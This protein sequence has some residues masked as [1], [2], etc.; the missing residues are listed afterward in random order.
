MSS[1][2]VGLHLGDRVGTRNRRNQHDVE[3]GP[4]ALRA[5]FAVGELVEGFE[6]RN[7]VELA[8]ALDDAA[9]HRVE[10]ARIAF[11]Q[12]LD[13]RV[14]LGDPGSFVEP[15]GDL[16]ERF[17]IEF[18]EAGA[19]PFNS[20][21]VAGECRLGFEVAEEVALAGARDAD[22]EASGQ[23]GED[24]GG[25]AARIGVGLVIA[26]R[27]LKDGESVVDVEREDGDR[28]EGAARRHDAGSGERAERGLQSDDAV[29]RRRHA[30]RPRRVGSER[31][32][33]DPGGDRN[34]RARARAAGDEVRAERVA[35]DAIGRTDADE[36][37]GELV[38]IGLADD[39]R[40]GLLQPLD[41]ERR[42]LRPV[43]EGGA[44]GRG[45]QA[46]DVDVVLDRERDA[47]Q[48]FAR[49]PLG[50]Q[51]LGDRQR[52]GLRTERY[53]ERRIGLARDAV[54]GRLDRRAQGMSCCVRGEQ[55]RDRMR[56][57][58]RLLQQ[59][60]II[61]NAADRRQMQEPGNLDGQL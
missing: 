46:D 13:R 49:R 39:D 60:D 29:Q 23:G 16:G 51:C 32:G 54:V 55:R 53:E 24:R 11:D 45:R 61:Q 31:K 33:D 2:G 27:R 26:V 8:R 18:N 48:R 15:A 14:A 37:R 36:A 6:R 47:E 58:V 34:R 35:G 7:R 5:P 20:G 3:V 4:D 12:R 22:P 41:D 19:E 43:G 9:R 59:H 21:D 56:H 30:S 57:R 40:A 50:L 42:R 28:V 1:N 17:E 25:K 44:A 10:R 52:V 38:E